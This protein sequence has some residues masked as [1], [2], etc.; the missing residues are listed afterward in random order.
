MDIDQGEPADM[1]WKVSEEATKKRK[2]KKRADDAQDATD[3]KID[4]K[5]AVVSSV[6]IFLRALF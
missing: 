5:E 2:G 1:G 6:S 3:I 4:S